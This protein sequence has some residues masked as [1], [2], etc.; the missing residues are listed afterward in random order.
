MAEKSFLTESI[1][2][3]NE[4]RNMIWK[5]NGEQIPNIFHIAMKMGFMLDP[6]HSTPLK[7]HLVH[8]IFPSGIYVNTQ[9]NMF[10]CE[11]GGKYRSGDVFDLTNLFPMSFVHGYEDAKNRFDIGKKAENMNEPSKRDAAW[12]K[13]VFSLLAY[14]WYGMV[15]DKVITK[16]EEE[17]REFIG[18]YE[19]KQ[20][21]QSEEAANNQIAN[22]SV[23]TDQKTE[24]Q[25]AS[26]AGINGYKKNNKEYVS[27]PIRSYL[28]RVLP[29]SDLRIETW[30]KR[31]GFSMDMA[32]SSVNSH[33]YRSG[34]AKVIVM[35]DPYRCFNDRTRKGYLDVVALSYDFPF[36]FSLAMGLAEENPT[37]MWFKYGE[38]FDVSGHRTAKA[39]NQVDETLEA[40]RMRF[41]K[42]RYDYTG[43][44]FNPETKSPYNMSMYNYL[45]RTRYIPNKVLESMNEFMGIVVDTSKSMTRTGSDMLGQFYADY[46]WDEQ[47]YRAYADVIKDEKVLKRRNLKEETRTALTERIAQNKAIIKEGITRLGDALSEKDKEQVAMLDEV[48]GTLA[49]DYEWPVVGFPVVKIPLETKIMTEGE[50]NG[51]KEQRREYAETSPKTLQ[52]ME[53]CGF[54]LKANKMKHNASKTNTAEGVWMACKVPF[55]EVRRVFFF[56]S[57][58]DA[59]SF[60]EVDKRMAEKSQKEPRFD[61][62]KDMLVSVA[63]QFSNQQGHTVKKL[64]P[65]AE[66]FACFDMDPAGRRYTY[67][68]NKIWSKQAV[69]ETKQRVLV[70]S[71]EIPVAKLS[72]DA[73][74]KLALDNYRKVSTDVVK[75]PDGQPVLG[76]DGKPERVARFEKYDYNLIVM[77]GDNE[78]RMNMNDI[79]I[80]RVREQIPSYQL[81]LTVLQPEK[82][83][84]KDLNTGNSEEQAFKTVKDWNDRLGCDRWERSQK[85]KSMSVTAGRVRDAKEKEQ[86]ARDAIIEKANERLKADASDRKAKGKSIS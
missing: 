82:G 27:E 43:S 46:Y 68:L 12:V 62:E 29:D 7:I 67:E 20:F 37:R 76:A 64:V 39:T 35:N 33:V 55:A 86:Q 63:G 3:L 8:S 24:A 51:Q 50:L 66:V 34:S 49:E 60:I 6:E 9:T 14:R 53:L 56:E 81:A 47:Q 65:Q 44:F 31:M 77:I 78:A 80:F 16:R 61:I 26:K 5:M 19:Y 36:E 69:R 38:R 74:R 85:V 59:I 28:H 21:E 11:Y 72:G 13:R 58:L 2:N 70:D 41:N 57:A 48:M 75:D 18:N 52:E 25:A 1:S 84:Y 71:V 32:K 83:S 30:L 4:L 10:S 15:N 40:E 42:I 22:T 79:S 54:E 17:V 45:N 23:T 73:E